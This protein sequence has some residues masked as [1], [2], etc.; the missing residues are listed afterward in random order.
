MLGT[1]LFYDAETALPLYFAYI[2]RGQTTGTIFHFKGYGI[3]FIYRFGQLADVYKYAFAIVAEIDKTKSFI[4]VE[5]SHLACK[6]AVVF[7]VLM[8]WHTDLD[9]FGIEDLHLGRIGRGIRQVA[10]LINIGH[11]GFQWF[12]FTGTGFTLFHFLLLLL[13]LFLALGL[14]L[15]F[16]K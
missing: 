15:S 8:L 5:K 4:V 9:I 13:A 3:V 11:H 10:V 14:F 12:A 1:A 16:T 6:G 7:V 2:D